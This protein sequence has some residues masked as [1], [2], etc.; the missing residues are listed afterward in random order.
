MTL[1]NGVEKFEAAHQKVRKA[2]K[3]ALATHTEIETVPNSNDE[4][5][6]VFN[7]KSQHKI[8]EEA[9]MDTAGYLAK[10]KSHFNSLAF[11]NRLPVELLVYIV[12]LTAPSKGAIPRDYVP[13]TWVCR[14]WRSVLVQTAN[15]WA[16]FHLDFDK[17]INPFVHELIRRSRPATLNVSMKINSIKFSSALED[18]LD[19][20]SKR[21]HTLTLQRVGPYEMGNY[22][23]DKPFPSLRRFGYHQLGISSDFS[24]LLAII[25]S[26]H[27]ETL[28]CNILDTTSRDEI[29]QLTPAL[30]RMRKI[31][32]DIY[33]VSLVAREPLR[34]IMGSLHNSINLHALYLTALAYAPLPPSKLTVLP[35]LQFLSTN[36][37]SLLTAIQAPKLLSLDVT[38]CS[39]SLTFDNPILTEFDFSSIKYFHIVDGG[40][41]APCVLGLREPIHPESVFSVKSEHYLQD[42]F[43]LWRLE[44]I[45]CDEDTD[46]LS[47][48]WSHSYFRLTFDK[49]IEIFKET[50][51]GV[52]PSMLPRLTG[53][54]E[55]CIVSGHMLRATEFTNIE[56]FL[57]HLPSLEVL[58]VP[59]GGELM[60][61]IRL[62]SDPSLCPRLN[63]VSY[64][65][66]YSD[67]LQPEKLKEF[68]EEIGKLL[69]ECIQSRRKT[70]SDALKFIVFGNCPPLPDFWLQELEGLGSKIVTARDIEI[71]QSIRP[72][73][74]E[75]GPGS[76]M[77][78]VSSVHSASEED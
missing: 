13:Y 31:G 74:V 46:I 9:I 64:T 6:Q 32:F 52:L 17:P 63:H 26:E 25:D 45:F 15:F 21:I 34:S 60:D 29:R 61:F 71:A 7:T 51:E 68:A 2:F 67:P 38:I 20:E 48:A 30:S 75:L 65:A 5:R 3:E 58:I 44:D 33:T 62:L 24:A 59:Y 73:V 53:L 1:S 23:G 27:L 70:Y 8:F 49:D 54:V 40:Y 37:P 12:R 66:C 41:S 55:L 42:I 36:I 78:S 50:L 35:E 69:T 14:Y 57:P 18:F 56:K 72:T 16:S 22:F 10:L 11:T 43:F 19:K 76:E 28:E 4:S 77:E 47:D 39:S